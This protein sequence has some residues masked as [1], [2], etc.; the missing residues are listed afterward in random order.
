MGKAMVGKRCG[1]WR[2]K[3][4]SSERAAERPRADG[5]NGYDTCDRSQCAA[6]PHKWLNVSPP[7]KDCYTAP[8]VVR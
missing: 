8:E 1:W 5:A 4:D 6:L 3:T 7:R 2:I